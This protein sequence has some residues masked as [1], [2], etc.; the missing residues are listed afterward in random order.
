V[1]VAHGVGDLPDLDA[2]QELDR[3]DGVVLG[4]GHELEVDLLQFGI[5]AISTSSRNIA[6]PSPL[7]RNSF[8][9][10]TRISAL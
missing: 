6:R 5:P 2:A 9:T 7:P 10:T 1:V 3:S 8:A 4:A